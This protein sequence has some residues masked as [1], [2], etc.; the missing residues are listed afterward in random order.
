MAPRPMLKTSD[1]RLALIVPNGPGQPIDWRR[2]ERPI[3]V[4]GFG[5][6]PRVRCKPLPCPGSAN[7]SAD[8]LGQ[9][10]PGFLFQPHP[11]KPILGVFESTFC[12]TTSRKAR[13]WWHR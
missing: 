5:Y 7:S 12:I 8:L 3:S 4:T 13:G 6:V 9:A 2:V 11:N 10:K 1:K